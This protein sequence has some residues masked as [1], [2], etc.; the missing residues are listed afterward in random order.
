MQSLSSDGVFVRYAGVVRLTETPA[1][2]SVAYDCRLFLAQGPVGLF[3]NGTQYRLR[4]G[5]VVYIP[6]AIPYRFV[7]EVASELIAVNFDFSRAHAHHK[8]FYSPVPLSDF[9]AAR[10]SEYPPKSF[11]FPIVAPS[12]HRL[13][14]L[15][16][17]VVR[18]K[19]FSQVL[20]DDMCS[21][22]LLQCLILLHRK[23]E[24]KATEKEELLVRRVLQYMEAHYAESMDNEQLA[25]NLSYHSYYLNRVFKRV[26]GE[27]LHSA[28]VRLRVA[29]AAALLQSGNMAV[30]EIGNAVG[31][32]NFSH[33]S[34]VFRKH[35]GLTP[36]EYR[37]THPAI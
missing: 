5:D 6:P 23:T 34:K 18:E 16:E 25:A 4:E 1:F 32:P 30:E 10:V 2:F 14:R 35:I 19:R 28:L 7:P 31:F 21:L 22:L 20:S 37:K 29:R 9:D 36:A 15:L 17:E 33:F 26:T 13:T 3:L 8:E 11:S 12:A 27:T 24:T